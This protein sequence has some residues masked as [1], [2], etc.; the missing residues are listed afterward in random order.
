MIDLHTLCVWRRLFRLMFLKEGP[1]AKKLRCTKKKKKEFRPHLSEILI[2]LPVCSHPSGDDGL[3]KHLE[4][5]L[6]A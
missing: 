3:S 6:Y 1:R 4:F 2:V 5:N